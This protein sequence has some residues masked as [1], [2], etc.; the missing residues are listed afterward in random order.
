M[1]LVYEMVSQLVVWRKNM[2]IVFNVVNTTRIVATG[3]NAK[4]ICV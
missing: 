3:I 2:N 4:M 1:L